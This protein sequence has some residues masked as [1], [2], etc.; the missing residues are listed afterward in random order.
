MTQKSGWKEM[1]HVAAANKVNY[2]TFLK[3]R[4]S[5]LSPEEAASEQ[6][7]PVSE[8]AKILYAL[9]NLKRTVKT[10]GP[11]SRMEALEQIDIQI[12]TKCD[13]CETRISMNKRNGSNSSR[14]EKICINDC[15]VGKQI[16]ELGKYLSLESRQ[17]VEGT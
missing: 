15:P 6:P 5:G 11:M 9:R 1:K 12:V 16:Q 13:P 4:K 3:R 8:N 10:E 7:E 14:L 17:S 2:A